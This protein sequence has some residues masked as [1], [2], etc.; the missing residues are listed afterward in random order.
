MKTELTR[1]DLLG[2]ISATRKRLEEIKNVDNQIAEL[3]KEPF[4]GI[5]KRMIATAVNL[6]WIFLFTVMAF[7]FL[8]YQLLLLPILYWVFRGSVV[9]DRICKSLYK[10][11]LEENEEI[12]EE[13]YRQKSEKE[14]N[15]KTISMLEKEM[16]DIAM[17][18][19]FES[20]LQNKQAVTIQK[21]I[22]LYSKDT[23]HS[24]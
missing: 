2:N 22:E 4:T 8:G 20:Y 1:E 18:K 6:S 16:H 21:C 13:L 7:N 17:L 14:Y 24:Y 23:K 12:I 9:S 5:Q 3:Y 15:L 19:Q 10:K 11:Q